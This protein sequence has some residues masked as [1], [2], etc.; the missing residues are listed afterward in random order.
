MS[1]FFKARKLQLKKKTLQSIA[2]SSQIWA[3]VFWAAIIKPTRWHAQNTVPIVQN[4][5][6]SDNATRVST[7][8]KP[9]DSPLLCL[10]VLVVVVRLE[11]FCCCET[12]PN[13]TVSY[14]TSQ[15]HRT[16]SL[17]SWGPTQSPCPC[18]TLEVFTKD[19]A[20]PQAQIFSH[21]EQSKMEVLKLFEKQILICFYFEFFLT[22]KAFLKCQFI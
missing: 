8:R 18:P 2:Q 19:N 21:K 22:T 14:M 12:F 9:L 16:H 17:G 7:A 1:F 3:S 4:Q 10:L 6:C 20:K 5:G 13:P 15:G 11:T